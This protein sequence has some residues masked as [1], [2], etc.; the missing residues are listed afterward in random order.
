MNTEYAS[1]DFMSLRLKRKSLL[2]DEI[3]LFEFVHPDGDPL[4]PFEPGA[5]VTIIT[6]SGARRNYSLCNDP[7]DRNV[8]QLA[9]KAEREG[10]GASVAMVEQTSEGDE[11]KVA[12]PDNTFPLV[13]AD[14][15]LLI[16]GGIGITP[17][18]SMAMHLLRQGKVNFHIYYL[19]R[20]PEMTAFRD[21]LTNGELAPH[22]T[23][24]HDGGD[25][26]NLFDFWP[27]FEKPGKA[28]V[29]CCG[30]RPLMEEIR[31]VSGHWSPTLVHFEDFASDVR[32]LREDDKPFTV[33]HADSG[34]VIEIPADATILETLRAHG[35]DL[36]SSCE[37]GTCGTC[38]T[39]LVAGEVDHRDM[40]LEDHQ[41]DQFIMICVSRANSDELVL[42]W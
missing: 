18:Y 12:G 39:Q 13:D 25:L 8:Y 15:Y 30:P 23:I 26:D 42:R 40:V 17:I 10:R 37:S 11:L 1:Q 28:H 29:Y 36:P 7:A 14:E 21:E 32:A 34:E 2:A 16:A 19:T 20:G 31:G 24:H 3:W 35:V 9:I 22:V 38:R 33:R 6:P 41:R 4:P 5:H 27:L